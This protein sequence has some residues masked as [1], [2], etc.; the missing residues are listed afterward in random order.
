MR[1]LGD[2]LRAVRIRETRNVTRELDDSALHAEAEPE[3]RNLV[4]ACVLNRADLSLNASVAESAGHENPLAA[5]EEFIE[6]RIRLLEFLRIDPRDLHLCILLDTAVM[7]GLRHRHIGIRQSDVF[8]DNGDLH[9]FRGMVDLKDHLLPRLH[10]GGIKRHCHL[11]EHDAIQPLLLHHER[12]FIDRRCRT[13]LDDGICIH[14]TKERNLLLHLAWNRLL[15]TTDKD[16][17]LNADGTQLLDAVL[18]RLRLE[19]SRCT[20]VGQQSDMDIQ[21]VVLADLLLDL[22]DC[23]E[24]GQTLDVTDRPADLR[25]DDI[26]IVRLC[27]IVDTLLDFVRNVRNHLHRR[28]EIIAVAL[29]VE[30]GGVDLARGD[31]RTL[32]EIDVD[33]AL[34]V[35]EIEIRLRPVVR[36]EHLTVLIGAHRAGVDVDVGI[37]FLNGDL[38]PAILEQ[39]S[40]RCRCNALAK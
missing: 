18:G 6:I 26:G 5:G 13:I 8:A 11:L 20:D 21:R 23:L 17:R 4:L 25:D 34:V 35:P 1:R 28:A 36:N 29:L 10:I 40:E 15:R 7:K 38:Q 31:V 37:E 30:H 27:H 24:E 39:A 14:I 33:E 9:L 3:E 19:F 16:I 12:N 32:R 22:A 2:E